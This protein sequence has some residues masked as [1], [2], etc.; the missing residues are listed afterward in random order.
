VPPG[1]EGA[2]REAVKSLLD[3]AGRRNAMGEAARRVQA[4]EYSASLMGERYVEL[5]RSVL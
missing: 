1:D 4:A 2:L 3:D 5:Y